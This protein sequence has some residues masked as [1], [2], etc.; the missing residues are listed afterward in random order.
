ML[1]VAAAVGI[2][3][4]VAALVDV[5]VGI[6]VFLGVLQLAVLHLPEIVVVLAILVFQIGNRLGQPHVLVLDI[7]SEALQVVAVFSHLARHGRHLLL[8]GAADVLGKLL[9][10][11]LLQRLEVIDVAVAAAAEDL[12]GIRATVH[13]DVGA[14]ADRLITIAGSVDGCLVAVALTDL[15]ADVDVCVE[16]NAAVMVTAVDGIPHDGAGSLVVDAGDVCVAETGR[17]PGD[18]RHFRVV[19][20]LAA[21]EDGVDVNLGVGGHVDACGAYQA[22]FVTAAI[23]IVEFAGKQIHHGAARADA[24]LLSHAG[25]RAAAVDVGPDKAVPVLGLLVIDVHIALPLHDVVHV[26][27]VW[28]TLAA[29]EDSAYGIP[30]VVERLEMDV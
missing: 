22:L 15:L 11:P 28:G 30:G 3:G 2:A 26:D 29:A 7:G 6:V 13:V 12:V 4:H 27:M 10:Q 21:A 25:V 23:Y 16:G 5:D 18:C 14:S 19:V 24:R 17:K 9:S 1:S 8:R 20:P